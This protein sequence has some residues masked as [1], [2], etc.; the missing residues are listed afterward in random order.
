MNSN[1]TLSETVLGKGA[2]GTVYKGMN[3]ETGEE[4]AI[5]AL[6][7]NKVDAKS[8]AKEIAVL[9][10]CKHE[11]I[12]KFHGCFED[13]T[14][15]YVCTELARGGELF[16]HIVNRKRYSENDARA[17]IKQVLATLVY[18]HKNRIA[19]LDLK[20]ENLLLKDVPKN[21]DEENSKFLPCI[22]IADFG[23][24]LIVNKTEPGCVG[25]PGYIAPE[26]ILRKP[27]TTEPDIY[28]LGVITYVMLSGTMP[29]SGDPNQMIKQQVQG[30]WTFTQKFFNVSKPAVD[31]I[32]RCM[33]KHPEKR[34]T[35]AQLTSH[36][37]FTDAEIDEELAGTQEN[38][39]EY[40]AKL[41]LKASFQAVRIGI[42][43]GSDFGQKW[44]ESG[45]M[46]VNHLKQKPTEQKKE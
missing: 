32:M 37:W 38:L 19:H 30:D 14:Y 21:Y 39:K 5:K 29:F 15:F 8:L 26:V 25:T 1:F 11:N 16:D 34:P 3:N 44:A 42:A 35:A 20:P 4:V 7:K 18:L 33:D 40:M 41:K 9:K 6:V 46:A 17:I 23:T 27:Y 31:F 2:F 10:K 22:K 45:L 43:L 28:A 24:A 36:K 13:D 12:I